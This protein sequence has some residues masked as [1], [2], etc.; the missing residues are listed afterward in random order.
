M[1]HLTTQPINSS[2]NK[3]FN[4]STNQHI[5]MST[6]FWKIG[7]LA[8]V[9]VFAYF[10]VI[11]L[12]VKTWL[13]RDDYSH[14][15]LIP[16]ISFY[17]IYAK[18]ENL[19]GLSIEP[20]ITGGLTFTLI[21]SLMLLTGSVSS[22]VTLQQ[23]S[24]LIIIPGLV[25]MLFGI[26]YLKA[27]SLPIAYLIFMIP[28]LDWIFNKFRL[29]LQFFSAKMASTLLSLFNIPVLH[30]AQYIEL[31]NIT[32][33]VADVCS[34]LNYLVS[35]IAI[36]IPLAYFTQKNWLSRVLLIIFAL[37]VGILANPIRIALIGIWAYSGGEG[38]HGPSH[39]FR[40]LFVSASGF[41]FLFISAWFLTKI[42][43]LKNKLPLKKGK[44][45]K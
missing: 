23:Y 27:L 35:I 41:I 26:K 5:S 1:N 30:N 45:K 32:L 7:I 22:V 18:R 11:S 40:A 4:K 24:I 39:I 44:Q 12:L 31:P 28:N 6:V 33:E 42:P 34:G 37:I 3:P 38:L 10:N 21:G 14:G 16:F 9:F 2:T 29:P 8:S 20:N 43:F 36:G 15:F 17:F 25:L 13:S 19:K